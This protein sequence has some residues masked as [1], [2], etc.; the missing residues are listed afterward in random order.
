MAQ[1][2]SKWIQFSAFATVPLVLVLGNSMLVPVLPD[3]AKHMKLSELQSSLVITLFSVSAGLFI[4][5]IGYLSD[6]IRRKTVIVPALALYGAAG[7]MAGMAA[8]WNSYP[9]LIAM[10]SVQGLAAAGTAPIAMAL[11]GDM[12][13]ETKGE[14]IAI[15]E[16][17]RR[18]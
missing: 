4:P 1:S 2:K 8:V 3:M 18:N 6:R 7:I 15:Q 12:Y 14:A 13:K 9:L 11:V 17:Y 16:I 5:F 10:R